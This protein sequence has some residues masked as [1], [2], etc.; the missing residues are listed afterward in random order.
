LLS[1]NEV[2]KSQPVESFLNL[3]EVFPAEFEL[4]AHLGDRI[5]VDRMGTQPLVLDPSKVAGDKEIHFEEVGLN[6]FRMRGFREPE[7]TKTFFLAFA[8]ATLVQGIFVRT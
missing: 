5:S 8:L 7:T 3:I 1:G 2:I 6:V 4:A